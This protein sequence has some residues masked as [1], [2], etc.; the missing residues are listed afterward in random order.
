[1]FLLELSSSCLLYT[2]RGGAVGQ[3][4]LLSG[5]LSLV[6]QHVSVSKVIPKRGNERFESEFDQ[7]ILNILFNKHFDVAHRHIYLNYSHSVHIVFL[8]NCLGGGLRFVVD[9]Y[10]VPVSP[11]SPLCPGHCDITKSRQLN[12]KISYQSVNNP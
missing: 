1:M 11:A 9:I 6:S 8:M 10:N 12:H 5:Q 4:S 2:G 7:N 3:L